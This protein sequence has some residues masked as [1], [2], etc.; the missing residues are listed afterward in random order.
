MEKF[1]VDRY[2]YVL[3]WGNDSQKID[4][5]KYALL[6]KINWSLIVATVNSTSYDLVVKKLFDETIVLVVSQALLES[7]YADKVDSVVSQVKKTGKLTA[8]ATR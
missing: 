5:S 3:F 8:L 7:L 6:G 1:D 4:E 2:N